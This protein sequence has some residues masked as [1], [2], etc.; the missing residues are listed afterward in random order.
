MRIV[1]SS[2]FLSN[3]HKNWLD[4]VSQL[5]DCYEDLGEVKT[6]LDV[7]VPRDTK[8]LS[9]PRNPGRVHPRSADHPS[10]TAV[11]LAFM[12]YLPFRCSKT[13]GIKTVEGKDGI[14]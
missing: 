10:Q 14:R 8:S 4:S 12:G 13:S 5:V 11:V 6:F 1:E 9:L 7:K 2:S 3:F